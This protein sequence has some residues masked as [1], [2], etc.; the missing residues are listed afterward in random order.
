MQISSA[1]IFAEC[2][3]NLFNFT[4]VSKEHTQIIKDY[5]A[6][7][8]SAVYQIISQLT[9]SEEMCIITKDP[10]QNFTHQLLLYA[11]F[12]CFYHILQKPYEHTLYKYPIR[13]KELITIPNT[14]ML[15]QLANEQL[16]YQEN[17]L[18]F[19]E[20]FIN[21]ISY[22]Y[23]KSDD[24]INKE[25]RKIHATDNVVA[26]AGEQQ[27]ILF[28]LRN[29]QLLFSTDKWLANFRDYCYEQEHGKVLHTVVCN[30]NFYH[31]WLSL[32]S[33]Y[34]DEQNNDLNREINDN[35]YIIYKHKYEQDTVFVFTING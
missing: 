21:K 17:N 9:D 10:L 31:P 24:E 6:Q 32:L 5:L 4:H 29:P 28:A 33:Y 34:Q 27:I 1:I 25:L 23:E 12:T 11:D 22:Q 14:T 26:I 19:H 13:F 2:T 3:D 16:L 15:C 20:L 35:K 8:N 7:Y 18:F 30:L